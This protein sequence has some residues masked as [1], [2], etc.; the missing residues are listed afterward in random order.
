MIR[1]SP[2]H[3]AKFV[4]LVAEEIGKKNLP[5]V[6][7]KSN[8][9]T[10]WGQPDFIKTM[11]A[12]SAVES[13]AGIQQAIRIYYGHGARGILQ[14]IGSNYW[15]VLIQNAPLKEKAQAKLIRPLP[16]IKRRKSALELIPRLLDMDKNAISV[17]SLDFNLLLVDHLSPTSYRQHSKPP[18]CHVTHGLIREALFWATNQD[19]LIKEIACKASGAK[20]CE[21]KITFGDL[22]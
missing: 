1:F 6:L 12:E 4:D 10:N 8:L 3:L 18:I 22:E 7:E 21:F 17:H 16:E 5:A 13:Y 9:P 2:L 15:N 19:A 11:S 20:N 14:R